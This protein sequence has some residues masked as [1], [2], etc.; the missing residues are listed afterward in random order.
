MGVAA[1]AGS[2]GLILCVLGVLGGTGH[3]L[4]IHAYRLAPA[5]SVAPFIYVQLLTMVMFGFAVF[6]DLPDVWTLIGAGVIVASGIYLL[7]RERTSRGHRVD[8]S[9]SSQ[10]PS[11]MAAQAAIT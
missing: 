7:H 5:S 3:Y 6:G 2:S 8:R 10:P 1:D 4:F 9:A 11:V